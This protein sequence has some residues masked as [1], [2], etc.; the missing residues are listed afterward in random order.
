MKK[1]LILLGALVL[2]LLPLISADNTEWLTFRQYNNH[3]AWDGVDYT[4]I[5]G[6]NQASYSTGGSILST[7][8]AVANGYVYVGSY[9][10]KL[11]QL[12]ASNVSQFIASYTTGGDVWSS[13][14]VA[15][16]YVYVGSDDN[17]L[18]QLN[19]SNVS[20]LIASY[21]TGTSFIRSSPAV[22]NGY[23]YVGSGDKKLY[24][25]NA[26][27]VS[28]LIASYTTGGNV[29][30][31]PAVSDGYVY[32]SSNDNK[33]YQLNASNVSQLIANYTTGGWSYSPPTVSDGYVYVGS[34]DDKLYQLNASNV[35][36]L[37]A[38]YTTGGNVQSSPAVANGYVYVGSGDKKLYQLNASNVSQL[39]ASYT[40][41]DL[42][43]FSSPAVAN[44]YVYVGSN[45]DKLYQLN[46]SN[47]SQLIASYTTGDNIETSPAI[48]NGY[49][50]V[51]SND[52][53]LYQ[54][55]ASDISLTNSDTTPPVLTWN[56]HR[57][58][59]SSEYNINITIN[60]NEALLGCYVYVDSI[61]NFSMTQNT[62]T[63]YYITVPDDT[64]TNY[65]VRAYCNDT[66]NNTGQSSLA[67]Y[68][69]DT[70][71]SIIT[72]IVVGNS[73]A[74]NPTSGT[75]TT[76]TVNMSVNETGGYADISNVYCNLTKGSRVVNLTCA[77]ISASGTEAN[78]T[79]RGNMTYFYLSGN[80]W[81][82]N[83]SASDAVG[84][85]GNN[86]SATNLTYNRLES[87][88]VTTSLTWTGITTASTD[89]GADDNPIIISNYG[90]A[91]F[92]TVNITAYD[93]VNGGDSIVA[94]DFS[95]NDA[96]A[97]DGEALSNATAVTMTGGSLLIGKASVENVYVYLEQITTPVSSKTYSSEL[98]W[99]VMT[100][101]AQNTNP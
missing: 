48:A 1:S 90:N 20:Q 85:A 71:P 80:D 39:I 40:T 95:C 41:G 66:A 17:K 12:N 30:S 100:Y 94:S 93:L 32:I 75:N 27:N 51:G 43:L 50:Y 64:N 70:T 37:I 78:Y 86:V 3:T 16:G 69:V 2:L 6:L 77:Q 10:N 84:N 53:K 5:S 76:I 68:N 73:G 14:A 22:A 19:A 61:G 24:Q 97:A 59:T 99:L 45:D 63:Q 23:V 15:N 56:W 74:Y 54:L 101:G 18:Y 34:H 96:D 58:I 72:N 35:S 88:S 83:C 9:D 65:S 89:D 67:W 7:S 55:N 82:P 44:G 31:S 13:P 11:Y 60:S 47:V 28:Q 29:R 36:Q 4:V 38:S 52:H 49:V 81:E 46:A 87:I 79:C 25:L 91:Y 92:S 98:P 42:L 26:S 8:P 62:T 33:L 21:T 57:N